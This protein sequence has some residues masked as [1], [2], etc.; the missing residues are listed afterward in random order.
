VW[1]PR[2]YK[3]VAICFLNV[4]FEQQPTS[5]DSCCLDLLHITNNHGNPKHLSPCTHMTRCSYH[6]HTYSCREDPARATIT[7]LPPSNGYHLPQVSSDIF[8]FCVHNL[9]PFQLWFIF[10]Y[11]VFSLWFLIWFFFFFLYLFVCMC[12]EEGRGGER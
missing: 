8:T 5:L 7:C 12:Q 11:M 10:C 2:A 3:H 6:M 4:Y 9:P 1:P